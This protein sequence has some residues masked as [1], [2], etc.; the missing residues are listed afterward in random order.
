MPFVLYWK[1]KVQAG[2]VYDPMVSAL[3]IYP[4]CVKA[5]GG[6][7]EQPRPLD[8]V[9]LLPFLTGKIKGIPHRKLYWRK[10]ECAAMRDGEWKL[11]R[12]EGL[13]DHL[14][15]LETDIGEYKDQA[16]AQ[17][18]RLERMQKMLR[19]WESDKIQ[20]LWQEGTKWIKVRYNDHKSW[21]KTGKL[22]RDKK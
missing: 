6:S 1:G 12:V 5:G 11:I 20:P 15:N 3:D 9:D 2:Q 19:D 4:T 18:E 7:L 17:P 10:L 16:T 22:P 8:G 21:F 13:E 14:F